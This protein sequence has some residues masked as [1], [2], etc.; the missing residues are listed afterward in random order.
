MKEHQYPDGMDNEITARIDML[1]SATFVPF[2][3]EGGLR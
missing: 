1:Y 3:I 2:A